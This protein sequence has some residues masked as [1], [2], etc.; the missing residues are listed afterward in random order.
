MK[1]LFISILT[2]FNLILLCNAQQ[3]TL[4]QI[5]RDHV[6]MEVFAGTCCPHITG[7]ELAI[8]GLIE[9]EDPVLIIRHDYCSSTDGPYENE[10]ATGRYVYYDLYADPMAIFNGTERVAG[11]G[12]ISLLPEYYGEIYPFIG[13]LTQYDMDL[14]IK[15]VHSNLYMANVTIKKLDMLPPTGPLTLQV[16]LTADKIKNTWGGYGEFEYYNC[17]QVGMYPDHNGTPVDFQSGFV[18]KI[19]IPVTIDSCQLNNRYHLIAFLQNDNTREIVQDACQQFTFLDIQLDAELCNVYN[20]PRTFC[21]GSLSPEVIIRNNGSEYLKSI[22]CNVDINDALIYSH[23]FNVNLGFLE[24]DTFLIPP[25]TFISEITNDIKVYISNP[26]GIPSQLR[27]NDTICF[28]SYSVLSTGMM[29]RMF[30]RTDDFPEETSWEIIDEAGNVVHTGGPYSIPN[31]AIFDTMQL[32]SIGCHKFILYDTGGNGL[33]TYFR[34]DSWNNN[35]WNYMTFTLSPFCYQRT[36]HFENIEAEPNEYHQP[37]LS[38]IDLIKGPHSDEPAVGIIE[39]YHRNSEGGK[40][41]FFIDMQEEKPVIYPNPVSRAGSIYFSFS[42]FNN[43]SVTMFSIGN[44]LATVFSDKVLDVEDPCIN[45]K[46]YKLDSGVYL[47]K[48]E[49]DQGIS[50]NKMLIQ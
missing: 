35:S 41:V 37:D 4:N 46:S 30:L 14:H 8:I 17:I 19:E 25:L 11:G 2:G 23:Q 1:K 18:Q 31:Q 21:E 42:G 13:Q 29:V 36:I 7:V 28:S 5:Q 27:E 40:Q 33:E 22:T 9:W 16:A 38:T 10:Y 12:P 3:V 45:L 43:I 15:T 20:I 47:V 32:Y 6:L 48:I 26:N 50:F 34:L 44:G 49:T 39:R 24:M